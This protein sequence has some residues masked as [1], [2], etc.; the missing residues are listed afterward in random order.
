VLDVL[1]DAATAVARLL[2][3][4]PLNQGAHILQHQ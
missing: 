2:E 4:D 3:N 1:L